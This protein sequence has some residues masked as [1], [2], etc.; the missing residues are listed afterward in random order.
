MTKQAFFTE[1]KARLSGLPSAEANER[2]SFYDEMINDR[3]EDGLSE[4]EAVAQVGTPEEISNQIL[5]EIPL[6]AL[7]K[8]KVRP[9]R[10]LRVWEII[11]LILGFPLWFPLLLS[12]FIIIL[13]F[14]I[15]IWSL[16][17]SLFAIDLS[18][19]FASIAALV[20]AIIYLFQGKIS[21]AVLMLGASAICAGLT[22]LLFIGSITA[23]KGMC[24]VTKKSILGIKSWFVRKEN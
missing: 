18:L 6:S 4:E 11:L 21:S 12:A 15:V 20:M 16:V 24:V 9:K 7:V 13:S 17:I 14:Y 10:A 23:A 8:E 22:V 1:L 19:G 5:S 2:F 3:I